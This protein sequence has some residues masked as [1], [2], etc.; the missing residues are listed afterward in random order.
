MLLIY[1]ACKAILRAEVDPQKEV[2]FCSHPKS[3]SW[4]MCTWFFAD[5]TYDVDGSFVLGSLALV[6]HINMLQ[7]TVNML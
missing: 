2:S 7:T 3:S 6:V 4:T 5:Q 1:Q